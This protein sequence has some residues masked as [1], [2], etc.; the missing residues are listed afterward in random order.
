MI[1]TTTP[2]SQGVKKSGIKF[3][4]KFEEH[5]I[6]SEFSFDYEVLLFALQFL[7]REHM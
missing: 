3:L 5:R 7:S 4:R 6:K 2:K 1:R